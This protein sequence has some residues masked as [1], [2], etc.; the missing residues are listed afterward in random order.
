MCV[1]VHGKEHSIVIKKLLFFGLFFCH[2]VD[3]HAIVATG[4]PNATSGTTFSFSVGSAIYD[5]VRQRLWTLSGQDTSGLSEQVQSYGIAY[6]PLLTNVDG[7]VN[8]PLIAYPYL[9]TES[10]ITSIE[11][12]LFTISANPVTNP[13]LGQQFSAVSFLGELLTC[14]DVANPN[15]IYC[16]QNATFTDG[17]FGKLSSQGISIINTLDLGVDNQAVALGTST[18]SYL[19]IAHAQGTFGTN[20]SYLSFA[21]TINN[22]AVINGQPTICT[23]M[24]Q[25]ADI[26]LERSTPVV[27]AG[28]ADVASI[29]TQVAFCPSAINANQ[30][31]VGLDVTAGIGTDDHAV[32]MFTATAQ[33]AVDQTPASITLSSVI[34]DAV[35]N[36]GIT[37][38]ISTNAAQRVAVP[39]ITTT[40]TS[41]GLSYCITSRFDDVGEQFVY[42]MP[43]VTMA[44][45]SANNGKIANLDSIAQVFQIIGVTYRVQ[46]FDSVISDAE[47]INIASGS[48]DVLQRLQ[49]GAGSVPLANGQFIDQL[50]A[51]GDAV[52]ITIQKPFAPGCTP[53]MFASQALFD[54]QGKIIAWTPWQRVA[55]SDDQ[56]L[57]SIKD[58]VTDATMYVSGA[59]SNTVQQTIWNNTTDL[60]TLI[61]D[62]NN[63]LPLVQGG[64][65]S[66]IAISPQTTNLA[67][68]PLAI[69]AGNQAV[70]IAQTGSLNDDNQIVIDSPQNS[71]TINQELG[72]AL[73]SVVAATFA[74]LTGVDNNWLFLGGDHGL[75]VVSDD[76]TGIGFNGQL[77]SLDQL[78][79][80]GQSCKT[81][82]NFQF[83]KKI[84]S[85]DNA[86]YVLTTTAV[87]KIALA[88]AK[89][90]L[91]NPAALQPEL[92][93]QG[94]TTGAFA[95]CLD[96]L[97]DNNTMLLGTTA[98]LYQI[99][100]SDSLPANPVSITIPG[101]LAAVSMLATVSTSGINNQDFYANSNLYV[102]TINFALQQA[103]LNRFTITNGVV[104]PIQ[105][106]LFEGQNGPLLI[107]D[108]M[109]NAIFID[110]SLGFATS[111]KIGDVPATVKYLQ[112][113]VQ[114]GKS[115]TQTL[116][117]F[118][119]TDISLTAVLSALGVAG[120]ARDYASGCLM[121]AG[122]FGLLT[123]S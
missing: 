91:E 15:I 87:Y 69:A 95:Y 44:S 114:A 40:T 112:Y 79:A 6:T 115:S 78:I 81:L 49:V 88:A 53:G 47:Q 11:N 83:V 93:V 72:L 32:G 101:G 100:L 18:G 107:F 84:V 35:V 46:G 14:V 104:E 39:N 121:L 113:T 26:V 9:P 48:A 117:K 71:I 2:T 24:I 27:T 58:R 10:Y 65:Q 42:A 76:T 61:S 52:Y 122:S 118:H 106:Q 92:V 7:Y 68:F 66:I 23:T 29:T 64:V 5:P 102:L 123:D 20:P 54:G 89:F 55:G 80:A 34:P 31:Y 82:G 3:V 1:Y 43:M 96:M 70:V 60:T 110:G 59:S 19:F 116:L 90:T 85:S 16:A 97:V 13:L 21:T 56:M 63:S 22:S 98:G 109:S 28:G 8:P 37:T 74:N 108:Y 17:A 4:D 103:C 36:Q 75:A 62:I 67:G 57:F 120:I 119:T 77:T 99:D 86:L 33:P 12:G 105:D 41:T 25:Q 73:G 111:Y 94:S 38:P 51:Q 30:I 45:E 50:V